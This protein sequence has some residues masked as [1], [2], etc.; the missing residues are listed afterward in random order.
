MVASDDPDY[1]GPD[2][3]TGVQRPAHILALLTPRAPVKLVADIGT[4]CGILALLAARHAK[5]VVATD[6]NERA[7]DLCELNAALNGIENIEVR[8]GSFLEPLADEKC[9]LIVS[10]PPFLVS[11]ATDYVFRDAGRGDAVSEELVRGLEERLVPGGH[12]VVA[13][14]WVANDDDAIERPLGWV[15]ER[16]GAVLLV[17]EVKDAV[18]DAEGWIRA[19]GSET[20]EDDF[21]RWRRWY[22][23]QGI[24]RLAYGAIAVRRGGNG[25]VVVPVDVGELGPAGTQVVRLLDAQDRRPAKLV[26]APDARL[27][28]SEL[29]LVA[30]LSL[31]ADLGEDAD[32]LRNSLGKPPTPL[33]QE[34]Y[35]L[36]FLVEP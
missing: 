23:E 5:R 7:L 2:Y 3:V 17:T 33:T 26:L 21:H 15:G 22:E 30:G 8:Q 16:N 29:S 20:P 12:A 27:E 13:I 18:N 34:L 32:A 6:V 25:R 10:N 14:S 19:A 36:G 11:P 9:D 31:H 35:E 4:G 1:D 28:G 24:E